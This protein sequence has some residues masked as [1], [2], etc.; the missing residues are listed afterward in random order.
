MS[1]KSR[2]NLI[3]SIRNGALSLGLF[4][5]VTAAAIS[6]TYV[7]GIDSIA[8]NKAEA[9]ARALSAVMPSTFYDQSLLSAP[10]T[11]VDYAPLNLAPPAVGYAA[12][13]SG[14]RQAM[15]LPVIAKDGYSGDISLLLG[16]DKHGFI[17]GV[18]AIEHRETPGLGDKVDRKKSPWIDS[19]IGR[20]LTNTPLD[21]WAVT[22]DG[23]VFDGFT[24][25]TITPRAVINAIHKGLLYHQR[26]G[27]AF[28]AIAEEK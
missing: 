15:V 14:R 18:R 26:H 8:A 10:V 20:S 17:Q 25:A 24:G 22:K 1:S 19:F 6:L 27:N 16:I 7:A 21:D 28:Y 13:K 12:V 4:A 2:R 3:A 11:L 23:G 9:K 5:V